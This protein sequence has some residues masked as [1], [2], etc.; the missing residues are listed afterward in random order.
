VLDIGCGAGRLAR[1]FARASRASAAW[2][3]PGRCSLSQVRGSTSKCT[4]DW[5]R[6]VLDRTF[7]LVICCGVLDFVEDA[8]AGLRAIRRHLAPDGRAVVSAA[9]PSVVGIDTRWSGGCKGAGRLYTSDR[10]RDIAA[11]CELRCTKAR[12]L[13]GGS[14]AVVLAR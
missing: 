5:S 12:T 11:S 8:G 1:F 13:R 7:D 14:V 2:T 3:R 10:L 6:L 9:A 4:R